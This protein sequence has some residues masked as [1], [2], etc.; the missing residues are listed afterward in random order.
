MLLV[1]HGVGDF[2]LQT[3]WQA[4]MKHGGLGRDRERRRALAFHMSTY[5]RAF[6]PALVWLESEIGL[7]VVAVA[8]GIVVPHVVQDDNRLL[9]AHAR[10]VK[11]LDLDASPPVAVWLDQSFHVVALFALVLVVAA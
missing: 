1:C 5:L 7:A 11:G 2:V 9:A 8:A 10:R 4:R 6:A 3:D